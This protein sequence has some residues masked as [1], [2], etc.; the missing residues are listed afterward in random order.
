[1]KRFVTFLFV[2][3][4][5]L[6]GL[7]AVA[8][9][10]ENIKV[11]TKSINFSHPIVNERNEFVKISMPK[12][13]S[14]LMRQNKP[15]LPSYIETFTYQIGTVINSV[16][17]I[18]N[19]VKQQ[20][21]SKYIMPT[22][23]AVSAGHIINKD[24]KQVTTIDYGKD[25][26]PNTW[27]TYDVG[28]GRYNNEPCVIVKVQVLPIQYNPAEGIIEWSNKMDIIIEYK[29]PKEPTIFNDNYDLV[30]IGPSE[31]SNELAPLITHKI[32][33]MGVATIF[34]S[35]TDIYN[36]V[37]F[38]AQGRD[39]Q[40][41]IKY[42]IKD[43]I[44]N[45]GTSYVLLVGGSDKLPVRET[46]VKNG[47]DEEIF[48]SDLYYAD[49]Y[50]E[51]DDFCSWDSNENDVFGEYNWGPSHN[52]DEVDLYPDVYFGRLACVNG[53][54]VTTSVNKIITYETNKAYTKNWFNDLVVIGG[55]HAPGDNG[56]V[57]EGEF[58]N[59]KVMDIM[60]GFV[61]NKV[62]DSNGRLTG[63]LPTGVME[64]NSAINAGCGFIDFAG[65]GNTNVWATHAYEDDETWIPTP[66]GYY[67]NTKVKGLNNG[68]ELPIVIIGACSTLKFNKD[69][70]CFGWS[71]ILND[72][73]GGIAVCG[74]SG[75]D[76]FYLGE[77][78]IE[79]G[80]EKICIDAFEA[81]YDDGAMT[82]GEMWSGAV[83]DYIYP[84]MDDLDHKTVEEFQS[85]G[86]PSLKIRGDSQA[87][88]KPMKPSGPANGKVGTEYTFTTSTTDPEVD[89]VYYLFDWG[90]GT[91]SG[92]KGP[93]DSGDTCEASNKWSTAGTYEIK[94]IAK[95][96]NGVIS[97]WSEPLG[98]TITKN[99]AV[100]NPFINFLQ[101]H[102]ILFQLIQRLLKL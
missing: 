39:N 59:Q 26:Y 4:L 81:F 22:P 13:N 66:P 62:W 71:F 9:Q 94:A 50:N 52:Y 37:H 73:G 49:I 33:E 12:T 10:D 82:F 21:I 86:D 65:H 79:K 14:F 98:I 31:Y 89:E 102:P 61:P 80:F 72:N 99:R 15:L 56:A 38:P 51:T 24:N 20:K 57:P 88:N 96:T 58:V 6:S 97:D 84:G 16:S 78:V 23:E 36:G 29:E 83:S 91:S 54:E 90:D 77:Y 45:W 87:P 41:K 18:P 19:D 32:N 25:P 74:A 75:L 93:Y 68:D 67:L 1:M 28:R 76:W 5:V 47:D 48:V 46:H 42:F 43:A 55:D 7:G 17:C 95:D 101:Q 30:V 85:F 63:L 34:V 92:W 60:G 53:G 27:Y 70:D 2:G 69:P 40:E 44:E 100:N 3:I 35:L 8:L 64:I 11:E